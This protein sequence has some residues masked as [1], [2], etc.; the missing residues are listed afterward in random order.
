MELT[1]KYLKNSL[2]ELA[3]EHIDEIFETASK[4]DFG[5]RLTTFES[6]YETMVELNTHFKS[7]VVVDDFASVAEAL[8]KQNM[9]LIE[10]LAICHAYNTRLETMVI[11]MQSE[12]SAQNQRIQE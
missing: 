11:T 6:E 9:V 7:D 3:L 2:P 1:C 10:Q 5:D 12:L 4:F 8:K